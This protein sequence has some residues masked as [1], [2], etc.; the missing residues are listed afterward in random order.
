MIK[1]PTKKTRFGTKLKLLILLSVFSLFYLRTNAQVTVTGAT[2]GNGSYSTLNSAIAAIV[3]SSQTGAAIAVSITGNTTE[4]SSPT[5]ITAGSWNS[6]IISPSGGSYTITG[7]PTAGTAM[8]QFDGADNVTIDGLNSGG[9]SLTITN[10]TV[11]GTTGTSTIRF[12]N[13]ATNNTI[14]KCTILGGFTAAVTTNGGNIFFSTGTTTGNDNNTISNNNIGPISGTS[15]STKGIFANGSTSSAAVGNNNNIISGNNIYDYFG[16]AV[17]SAG[18]Y[19]SGGN[20]SWSITNNK[21]YQS[22]T[23]T[24]TSG[25]QHSAIWVTNTTSTTGAQN[26]T[27]TGNT[28]GYANSSGTGVYALTGS[29]GKFIGIQFSGL[30]DGIEN[31]ISSNTIA[32]ISLTGVS[33]S[34]TT[35]SAP[36]IGFYFTG[37]AVTSNLNLIG[38]MS[39]TGNITLTST[40]TTATDFYGFYSSASNNWTCNKNSIGGLNIQTSATTSASHF[41]GIRSVLGLSTLSFNA[42]S[43]NIGGSIAHSIRNTSTSTSCQIKGIFNTTPCP[44]ITNNIVRNLTV[45]GGTGTTTTSSLVGIYNTSTSIITPY[46]IDRNTISGLT[47]SNSTAACVVAGIWHSGAVSNSVGAG[48]VNNTVFS[49]TTPSTGSISLIGVSISG[50]TNINVGGNTIYSITGTGAT[51]SHTINGISITGGTT[52]NA[53]SNKIYDLSSSAIGGIVNGINVISLT[54]LNMYNNVIGDLKAPIATS[55]DAVRGLN[56]S[57]TSIYNIYFNTIVLNASS[58]SATTFGN[59]CITFS[60]TATSFDLRNNILINISTPAQNA[61]NVGTNGIAA[62][63]RRSSGTAL[64]VPS[65]YSTNS[66]NNLFWVNPA[67]G[68]NNHLTYVE[69]TSTITNPMN[70]YSLLKAFMVNREQASFQEQPGTSA[71]NLSFVIST[72][73]SNSE[74]LKYVASTVSVAESG[75]S[76]IT[77]PSITTDFSGTTGNRSSTPDIG[78]YEFSGSSPAPFITLNSVSPSGTQCSVTSRLVSLSITTLSGTISGAQLTYNN[79]SGATSV[80]MVNTSGNNWEYTIPVASPA[81]TVVTWSVVATNSAGLLRTYNGGSYF[82]EPL[83]GVTSSIS[84]SSNPICI[85]SNS[86]L[87]ASLVKNSTSTLGA[88]ASTSNGVAASFL[89]GGWGGAKTQ[90]IIRASELTALGFSAGNQLSSI[91]FY[92]TSVG[93]TYQGFSVNIAHTSQSEMTTTFI[94]SGLTQ[95]YL[96]TLTNNGLLPVINS[97]NTLTFGTGTGSS[98]TF[99]WNGTSNIVVSFSWSSVPSA[100]NSTG[101]TMQVDAAGFTCSAYDQADSQTP[102]AMLASALADG[103]GT[104]RPKFIISG[105]TAPTINTISWSDGSSVVSTSNP[106][107][108]SASSTT[109]FTANIV[110]GGCTLTP[111]PFLSLNVATPPATP[112]STNTVNC[113]GVPTVS[114]TSNTAAIT[115][116]FKWYDAAIGGAVMQSSAST[117]FTT[118]LEVTD[119]FYVVEVDGTSSCESARIQTIATVNALSILPKSSSFCAGAGTQTDSFYV[120]SSHINFPTLT[121]AVLTPSASLTTTSGASTLASLSETSD[122][123]L[124]G[125]GAGCTQ[126]AYASI[127][128]YDFPSPVLSATPNDTISLGSQFTFN[129]GLSAGNFSSSVVTH[130]PYTAPLSAINLVTNGNTTVPNGRSLSGGSLDDGGWGDI[131]LGFNF[132]F[133]GSTYSKIAVGTNG[134]L[135]FGNVPGYGTG[136]GQL[137]QFNFSLTPVAF[138]NIGNPGN[139][140]AMVSQDNQLSTS[141]NVKYW[142]TGYA[143]NRKFIVQF[144]AVPEYSGSGTTTAQAIFF[145]TTGIVEIHITNAS[146]SSSRAKIVGLQDSTKTIGAAPVNGSTTNITNTA[147]RFTPPSNYTTIWTPALDIFGANSGTN[148][149]TRTSNYNAIGNNTINLTLT[150]TVTGCSNASN[151][152]SID[153]VVID[154]PVDP[155][156]AGNTIC[157]PKA[158]SVSVTN[159]GSF[160]SPA[161]SIRWYDAATNGNFLGYGIIYN[162]PVLSSTT[163]YYA[164]TWNGYGVNASGRVPAIVTYSAPPTLTISS[165]QTL[166]NNEVGS[167]TVTSNAANYSDYSWSPVTNLYSDALC[168]TPVVALA[169]HQTVYFKSSTAGSNVYTCTSNNASGCQETSLSTVSILPDSS[170]ISISVLTD[171]I[172]S[173]GSTTLNISPASGY[174]AGILRW[175]DNS[176]SVIV[177]ANSTSYTTPTIASTSTY[178]FEILNSNSGVCVTKPQTITVTNITAPTTTNSSQCGTAIPTCSAS[179]AGV[180]QIYRWYTA[181][182]GGSPIAGETSSTLSSYNISSSTTLYVSISDYTCESARTSVSITVTAADQIVASN[183]LSTNVC[184]GSSANISVTQAASNN[185]YGLTWTS[186]DYTNSGMSSSTS[187]SLSNPISITPT[188]IGTYIFTITGVES[189]SGCTA[190]DYDTL[191]VINPFGGVPVST[192]ANPS[193]FCAGSPISLRTVIGTPATVAIGTQT[194][195]EFGGGV[196]RNGFG[197]GDFR[198]QLLYTAAELSAAGINPGFLTSIAFTVT[199]AGTGAANNYTISL[200][201]VTSSPI[202]AS[203]LSPTFTQVYTAATYTAVAGL[204]THTFNTEYFWDGTSDILVNICYTMTITGGTSTVAATTP[205]SV[206]NVSLLGSVGACSAASGTTYANRPLATFGYR[207]GPQISSYSWSDGTSTVGSTNPL[208]VSPSTSTTYTVTLTSRGCTTTSNVT[209]NPTSLPSSPSVSPSA[210]CGNQIP[211]CS[212]TG[213]SSGDY[214]WYNDSLGGTAI[215][216]ETNGAL[217]NLFVSATDTLYVTISNGTCESARIPVY[218]VV[219]IPDSIVVTSSSVSNVCANTSINLS[220]SQALS[221]NTYSLTWTATPSVGSGITTSTSGSLTAPISVTPTAAGNYVFTLTGVESGTGCQVIDTVN[222]TVIHPFVGVTATSNATLSSVCAGSPTTLS[223]VSYSTVAATYTLPPPVTSPTADE[224]I[225]SVVIAQSGIAILSNITPINSLVGTIG[226]ASGVA[227]S[228]SNFTG[229]GPYALTAGQTYDIALSSVQQGGGYTNIFGVFI[230]YNRDGD[231]VDAG[232]TVFISTSGAGDITRTSTFTI[233]LTASNGLARMRIVN[234]EGTSISGPTMVVGFGE[235]EEYMLDISSSNNSGGYAPTGITYNW[236]N[237]TTSVGSTNPL[238]ASP[239]VATNYSATL[240]SSGCTIVSSPVSVSIN[241]AAATPVTPSV[242]NQTTT[243]FDLS[244]SAA[245]NATSYKL[246]IATDAL[247]ASMVSGYN[248]LTVAGLS[249]AVTGLTAGTTYYARVRGVNTCGASASSSTLTT[250]TRTAAPVLSGATSVSGTGMTINWSAT[251]GAAS[252]LLDVSTSNTFNTFVSGYNGLAVPTGTSQAV[253]GL[254]AGTRYYYR[255][256]AVNASGNSA[257]SSTGDTVTLSGSATLSLTAFFEGLYLGGSAMTPAPFNSDNTLPATIAD[258]ITVELHLAHGTFDLAYSVTDTISVNGTASISFP[259]AAVGN[260]YYI[261]VKHRNSL[262]TWSTDSILISSSLSY[263]FSSAAT[264]AYGSNMV[265]LGSGVFGI[266]AG[267]INQDGFIDGNDFTD[268]DNDNANFASGYLYTDTNGDGFV[269]GN[270]FTLIDNNGSMFIGIVRP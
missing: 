230:D 114:I 128:F 20:S 242:S 34:G 97:I 79:G 199:T 222:V 106:A 181:V 160:L 129:S 215:A 111:S 257:Y 252:Y 213:A 207:A 180:G 166:C 142:T 245:A 258:T 66:N 236:S 1:T 12:F 9:N 98:S 198:H 54:S 191:V 227:G 201:S 18:I 223:A 119:T 91:G 261:V 134:T 122:F 159:S 81:N 39:N 25:A 123:S 204:N 154:P 49:L 53:Y 125:S 229:F 126:I 47:N 239:A 150:N 206:S 157:G 226:T 41:V 212:A 72:V 219:T 155:I 113:P 138:P 248:D 170:T 23:R 80:S 253:T 116:I 231:F 73:G 151:P 217:G 224:D 63:I 75:A 43:N 135:M 175:L 58:T 45:N 192:T 161:D 85:G 173:S 195:T 127:G 22:A 32:S 187:T 241:P 136:A 132:N 262:E 74:F 104:S 60:S 51:G 40:T 11:S 103:T 88:G 194:T 94:S 250:I 163:T 13:D 31:T 221:N 235:Y 203:F 196:Y 260:Y 96:G 165:S 62:L 185:T 238:S 172:C 167:V 143:P 102:A 256:L 233:P 144:S 189:S 108:V 7:N 21:F 186:S 83:F 225:D 246:D 92:P 50:A 169:N 183:N 44:N 33:S 107:S 30:T 210:H 218:V 188:A 86:N 118:S 130:A 259:G 255:V 90:F 254:T 69:G 68:T 52:V 124:E 93:Q 174:S 27:I 266:Y 249:Q 29:T 184:L 164:E 193:T 15:L 237:G 178:T 243:G 216:G 120:S 38:S 109:T 84:A 28:I 17:T 24:W 240:T 153:V 61:T 247:F 265:D 146:T 133:F 269:D 131:P 251:T 141:G 42:D 214:R 67:S 14:T 268:V 200:A 8:I 59:S 171:T 3:G 148:L 182:S 37:G 177:G 65:N 197:T 115:P 162:T 244:W 158:S 264:Q 101:S 270:D 76:V 149:F 267:D 211:T 78:A 105:N 168:T 179:G 228:Y 6:L 147:Y 202:S 19:L 99:T 46:T 95:V 208:S 70:T 55:L 234:Y 100:T 35:T 137:G 71:T 117:T 5:V 176:N 140:V 48:V 10:S 77:S 232:E 152:A 2:S 145:E 16:G 263:D 220:A 209:A 110:A 205:A 156:T 26:F 57:A 190:I 112:S 36:F 87:T 64:T 121:W 56:A 89:P 82:D 139:V 4:G